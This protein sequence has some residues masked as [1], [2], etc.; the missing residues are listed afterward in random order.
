M[1][2]R[3]GFNSATND[4]E[5]F[6]LEVSESGSKIK[7]RG[8]T[9]VVKSVRR[10]LLRLPCRRQTGVGSHLRA[11]PWLRTAANSESAHGGDPEGRPA[12]QAGRHDSR[13]SWREQ[14]FR[15]LTEAA[16]KLGRESHRARL[17][18]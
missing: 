7:V 12:L 17:M 11:G 10:Q 4:W 15:R 16:A 13:G 18:A 1:K 3:E 9:D 2:H 6:E 8:V 5:F 14:G